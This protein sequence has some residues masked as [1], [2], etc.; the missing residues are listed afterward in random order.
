[1]ITIQNDIKNTINKALKDL[2]P[3]ENISFSVEAQKNPDFG[4]Y[5][6]NVLFAVSKKTKKSFLD[7]AGALM[8]HEA[9]EKIKLAF[10]ERPEQGFLNFYLKEDYLAEK[11]LS[12]G[13]EIRKNKKQPIFLA[14]F[15]NFKF[16]VLVLIFIHQ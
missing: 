14:V 5:S 12:F 7:V 2:Y 9:F 16:L 3:E 1:M 13:A 4:D 11:L 10:D 8:E 15:Y 6:S